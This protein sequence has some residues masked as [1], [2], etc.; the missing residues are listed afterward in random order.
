MADLKVNRD[1]WW[2]AM[3]VALAFLGTLP[4]NGRALPFRASE[5]RV[6]LCART[7]A[8]GGDWLVPVYEG[9]VRINKPPLMYWIVA[10]VFRM[11]GGTGSLG[12]A[13]GVNAV[14]GAL[15][16]SAIYGC[17]RHWVGRRRAWVAAA[18]AATSYLYLYFARLCETDIGLT[19][20]ATLACFAVWRAAVH[21]RCWP[22]WLL[23]GV[24]SGIGFLFKGPAAVVLPVVALVAGYA[25]GAL[26][27][28]RRGLPGVLL[29]AIP[30][31]AIALP[32]YLYLL[33]GRS[34]GAAGQDI[35]YEMAALLKESP[36]RGPWIYYLYTLPLLML[37][38]GLFLPG[39]LWRA[40]RRR[41]HPRVRFVLGWLLSAVAVLTLLKSK[42]PHYTMLLLPPASLLAGSLL[43]DAATGRGHG[44]YRVTGW[45]LG[46]LCGIVALAGV[47][48]VAVPFRVQ[49]VSAG[50][51]MFWGLPLAVAA[52][53]VLLVRRG[54]AARRRMLF[55]SA[56]A[57]WCMAGYASVF[58]E[59]GEPAAMYREC[60]EEAGLRM[61]GDTRVF[62]VG[63]RAV[64]MQYYLR[65]PPDRADD[66]QKAWEKAGKG[67]LVIVSLD[68]R[69][70]SV[71]TMDPPVAPVFHR[72]Q[73]PYE[74]RMY[75]R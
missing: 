60:A 74:V 39:G 59:I 55:L 1:R 44:S 52:V 22:W 64:P 48:I 40:W 46:L 21:A 20:S 19:L 8:E 71:L 36:H 73:G 23:A 10:G 42:Q 26:R 17:G 61:A 54:N 65:R 29:M 62:H 18:L 56:A 69:N 9:E 7:M 34:S 16:V 38:W 28:W 67:D 47:A 13:R 11:A 58:H 57:V 49:G 3:L 14:L 15:L 33:L 37:P 63:R 32:W 72:R 41:H 45:L 70:R 2:M 6:L 25:T 53:L 68:S 5:L 66:L 51:G 43:Y 4:W 24:F 35:G 27:E 50:M 30:F 75:V 31:V 12:L